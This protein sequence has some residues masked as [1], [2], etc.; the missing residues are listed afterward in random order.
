M[1]A[2]VP[3][4]LL[5]WIIAAL[6]VI[7]NAWQLQLSRATLAE[8][9]TLQIY[10]SDDD[11]GLCST[12]SKVGMSPWL[13]KFTS[14]SLPL[15]HE[16]GVCE[17]AYLSMAK[18]AGIA[19]PP[20]KLVHTQASSVR[21]WLGLRRFDCTPQGGRLHMH[22]ACRLLDADFRLPSLDYVTLINASSQLCK[23]PAA[24]QQQFR[25]A[26]FNLFALNQDDHSK[27]FA[28]LQDETGAWQLA[29]LYD[30]TFSPSVRG[31]HATTF[32][33]YGKT[34]PL[35]AVQLLANAASFQAWKQ[36]RQVVEEVV[37]S[38]SDLVAGS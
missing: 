22:S 28:F 6:V 17:A 18:L 27:N 5:N 1:T 2:E 8:R 11:K 35:K 34:P 24:A 14:T 36:A 37:G 12:V 32:A 10:L 3:A 7:Q 13:V 29:P 30:A 21:H 20:W 33:G 4:A 31:E 9:S 23:S 15:Q 38:L 16:E 19:V 26:V 25:R